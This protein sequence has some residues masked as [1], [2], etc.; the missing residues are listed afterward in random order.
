MPS[1][2]NLR[3]SSTFSTYGISL[4]EV[5]PVDVVVKNV[6]V[7]LKTADKPQSKIPGIFSKRQPEENEKSGT[8]RPK[9]ILNNVSTSMPSGTLTAILGS[10]GSGKTT[11]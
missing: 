1:L 6:T 2:G 10:S 9:A 8:Q 3:R 11:L 4:R 7:T 5:V